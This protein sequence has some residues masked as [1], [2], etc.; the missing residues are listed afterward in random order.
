MNQEE[1]IKHAVKAMEKAYA[2][3]SKFCVGAALLTKKGNVYTGCNI[4][5]ASYS[6]TIC[7]ERCSF[8]TAIAHGE[9]EFS[10]IAVV[11]GRKGVVTKSITPCG[12]CRQ[13]MSEFCDADFKVIC[14]D[15]K[16]IIE[17]QLGD[18]LPYSF[19]NFDISEETNL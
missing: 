3:Y 16:N 12:V 11:G 13:F 2:P 8:S 7:A 1:L 4:E 15:G 5:N 17:Y 6:P 10:A 18:L 14:W 19:S 9:N